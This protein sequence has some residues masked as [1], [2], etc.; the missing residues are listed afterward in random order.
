MRHVAGMSSLHVFGAVRA[1]TRK[2]PIQR[3]KSSECDGGGVRSVSSS[4]SSPTAKCTSRREA[5]SST[6]HRSCRSCSSARTS[7]VTRP[8]RCSAASPDPAGSGAAE[9]VRGAAGVLAVI[10]VEGRV[11]GPEERRR[12]VDPNSSYST[13]GTKGRPVVGTLADEGAQTSGNRTS[14]NTDVTKLRAVSSAIAALKVGTSHTR[15][16]RDRRLMCA[17]RKS[18]QEWVR[19]NPS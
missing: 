18:W 12:V 2:G 11:A 5:S 17:C 13:S 7:E 4:T 3:G 15:P 1:R 6:L 8:I 9:G 19:G 10:G 14:R 16:V